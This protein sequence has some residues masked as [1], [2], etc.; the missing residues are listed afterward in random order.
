MIAYIDISY[1]FS[2]LFKSIFTWQKL[3]G[4]NTNFS[5]GDLGN[6]KNLK[7]LGEATSKLEEGWIFPHFPVG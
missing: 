2:L 7:T 6:Y 3:R 5:T 4:I 1:S